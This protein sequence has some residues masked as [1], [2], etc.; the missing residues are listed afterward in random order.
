MY[1]YMYMYS[2]STTSN[3]HVAYLLISLLPSPVPSLHPLQK[4]MY[5][6]K[7]VK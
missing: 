2:G 4:D 7:S 1:E 5:Q 3:I 6:I